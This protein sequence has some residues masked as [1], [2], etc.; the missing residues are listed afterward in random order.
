[1]LQSGQLQGLELQRRLVRKSTQVTFGRPGKWI[2]PN[3]FTRSVTFSIV[4]QI[5]YHQ[6]MKDKTSSSRASPGALK[7]SEM[8]AGGI[9]NED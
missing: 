4:S 8:K 6:K 3:F 2:A 5:C 9:G 7:P 1:M